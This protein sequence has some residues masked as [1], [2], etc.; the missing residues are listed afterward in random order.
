MATY[1]DQ[2]TLGEDA[3][4]H[5]R[6]EQAA[7]TI[8]IQVLSGGY[9]SG[10]VSLAEKILADPVNFSK[11]LSKAVVTQSAV[12]ATAPTGATLSDAQL[13]TAVNTILSKFV[14]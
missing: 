1:D 11:L 9:S 6:V 8:A 5:K 2:Y 3:S 10:E 12:S 14:R 13:Q 4:F 7:I